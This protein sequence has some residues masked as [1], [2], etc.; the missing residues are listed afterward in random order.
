MWRAVAKML[1]YNY[2]L[3]S[4]SMT[5]HGNILGIVFLLSAVISIYALSQLA[6]SGIEL[7]SRDML[8]SS[9]G[10]FLLI[11]AGCSLF[12]KARIKFFFGLAAAFHHF[13]NIPVGTVISLYFF[14]YYYTYA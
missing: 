6:N 12:T 9:F 5:K 4:F 7:S 13:I 1:A 14:W 11:L 10:I 8:L 3:E 2:N